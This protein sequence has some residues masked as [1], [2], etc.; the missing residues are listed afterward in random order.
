MFSVVQQV[1][2]WFLL[3]EFASQ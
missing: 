1:D 3:V 2:V